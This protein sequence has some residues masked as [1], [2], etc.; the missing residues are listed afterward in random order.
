MPPVPDYPNPFREEPIE[1]WT[2]DGVVCEIRASPTRGFNGY[3]LHPTLL[4]LPYERIPLE[5]HGG[6]TYGADDEGRI[7][8]DTAH[9]GD[10]WDEAVVMEHAPPRVVEYLRWH[11]ERF[12]EDPWEIDR[13]LQWTK[14][15]T[16]GELRKEVSRLAHSATA[17]ARAGAP[18]VPEY[19]DDDRYEDDPTLF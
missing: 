7:G 4:G 8:F 16:L 15:W 13:G 5:C 2:V 14:R 12:G 6:L 11:R 3:V 9:S 19:E 1:R 10:Y 18:L 17:W